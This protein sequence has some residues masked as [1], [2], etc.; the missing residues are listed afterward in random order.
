MDFNNLSLVMIKKQV[1]HK[2]TYENTVLKFKLLGKRT[3]AYRKAIKQQRL[4]FSETFLNT[5]DG[6]IY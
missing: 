1:E 3:V 6:R 2:Q 4:E 5:D